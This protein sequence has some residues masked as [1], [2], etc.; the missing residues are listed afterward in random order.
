MLSNTRLGFLS[1]KVG[2]IRVGANSEVELK[3]KSDRVDDAICAT[4]AA[5]KEGVVPG[6][7]EGRA[8]Y[9]DEGVHARGACSH[10][11]QLGAP[12][13]Q[14]AAETQQLPVH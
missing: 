12:A 14:G 7:G 2:V 10:G 4:R 9:A 8:S 6:G 1:C 5:I 3:E 11:V 13:M